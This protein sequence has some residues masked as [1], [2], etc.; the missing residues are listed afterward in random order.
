VVD[1]DGDTIADACDNCPSVSNPDQRDS[2]GQGGGDMCDAC[3]LDATDAC[4]PGASAAATLGSAGGSFATADGHFGVTVPAGTLS[5]PT[6][7]SI[8]GGLPESR[9]GVGDATSNLALVAEFG[10]EGVAFDP[11]VTLRFTW[12][13]SDDD[14]FVDGFDPA[15]PEDFLQVWRNGVPMAGPCGD[16]PFQPPLCSTACC[17]PMTNTWT[18]EVPQFSEYAVGFAPCTPFD[19]AK[20]NA[21]HLDT[22]LGDDRLTF[23][24]ETTLSPGALAVFDPLAHGIDLAL[25]NPSGNVLAA[26]IPGGAYDTST[27]I[28]WKT[29]RAATRWTYVN[30]S[31]PGTD[32]IYAARLKISANARVSFTLKGKNGGYPLAIGA[33]VRVVLPGGGE[34]RAVRFTGAPG[35]PGCILSRGG[36]ALRCE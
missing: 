15:L 9:Y 35:E 12:S 36:T 24:A 30:K 25:D 17:D 5:N 2:D 14:G 28:G 23:K 31:S 13:D 33:I 29:N 6:S 7:V 27:R 1:G 8:T 34:C 11:P 19:E 3:A 16:P 26:L 32:G 21:L 10:P 20:L 22:P 18:L 4:D